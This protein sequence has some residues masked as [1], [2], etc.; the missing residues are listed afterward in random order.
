MGVSVRDSFRVGDLDFL[1]E[2]VNLVSEL[3]IETPPSEAHNQAF[4]IYPKKTARHLRSRHGVFVIGVPV[5]FYCKGFSYLF[6]DLVDWIERSHGLLE[7]CCNLS[8]P[9]LLDIFFM[10]GE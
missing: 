1:Q 6:P 2:F 3:F 8:A 5:A 4:F 9:E 10:Q 7:Y